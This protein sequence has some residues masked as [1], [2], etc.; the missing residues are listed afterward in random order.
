MHVLAVG[1]RIFIW[2]LIMTEIFLVTAV[3]FCGVFEKIR[4]VPLI[5]QF[6]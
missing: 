5:R 1:D 4:H 2:I 3:E 6:F